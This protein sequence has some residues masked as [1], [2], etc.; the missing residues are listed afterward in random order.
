MV[1]RKP[2]N[3]DERA[4]EHAPV[5]H[6]LRQAEGAEADALGEQFSHRGEGE[7]LGATHHQPGTK[8]HGVGSH[9][10]APHRWHDEQT[11]AERHRDDA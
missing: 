9:P 10:V 1:S 6:S 8:Q 3:V 5:D 7:E 4:L 2:E 11:K